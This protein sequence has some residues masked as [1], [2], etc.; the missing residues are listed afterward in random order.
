MLQILF[1]LF[2]GEIKHIVVRAF[3]MIQAAQW[4]AACLVVGPAVAADVN[5]RV[6]GGTH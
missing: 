3:L 4:R 2:T 6:N 1:M 5:G